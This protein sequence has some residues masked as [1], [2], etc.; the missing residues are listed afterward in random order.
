MKETSPTPQRWIW[1][2]AGAAILIGYSLFFMRDPLTST[3]EICGRA[4]ST[5][6]ELPPDLNNQVLIESGLFFGTV[7]FWMYAIVLVIYRTHLLRQLL[8]VGVVGGGMLLGFSLLAQVLSW[9]WPTSSIN[10]AA[11]VSAPAVFNQIVTAAFMAGLIVLLNE[12]RRVP[13]PQL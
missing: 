13:S 5:L 6:V 9:F 12:S 10:V 1:L 2:T 7:L 11:L 3:I 8:W 4:L